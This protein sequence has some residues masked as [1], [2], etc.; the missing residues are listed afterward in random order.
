MIRT[1]LRLSACFLVAGAGS[2]QARPL[3]PFIILPSGDTVRLAQHGPATTVIVQGHGRTMRA[4]LPGQ[5]GIY[6]GS[7]SETS[8]IGTIGSTVVIVSSDYASNPSGG[9]YQCGAGIETLVRVIALL[10]QPHQT[11]AQLVASCWSSIEAGDVSWDTATHLLTIERTTF[12]PQAAASKTT[13][14]DLRTTYA[15]MPQGTVTP[16]RVERLP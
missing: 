11:F 6:T 1:Y 9:R 5:P 12:P 13:V 8:L 3:P 4:L 15:I 7:L 10:P 16:R 14:E 2:V